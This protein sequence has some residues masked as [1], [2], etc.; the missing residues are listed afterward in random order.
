MN[1]NTYTSMFLCK[2]ISYHEDVCCYGRFVKGLVYVDIKT[3]LT[4]S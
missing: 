4:T 3:L 2:V 1:M